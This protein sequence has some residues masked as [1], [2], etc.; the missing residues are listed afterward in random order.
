MALIDKE[1]IRAEIERQIDITSI[2]L[3]E[4][5]AGHENGRME[6]LWELRDFIDSLPDEPKAE[7]LEEEIDKYFHLWRQGAS[8]EGCVNADSQFVSIYDCYRI[9]RHF[10]EWGAER[11]KAKMMEEA[12]GGRYMKAMGDVYVE[13]F[14]LPIPED[15]VKAG[16]K[17]KLIILPEDE[18]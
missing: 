10:A 8:D 13:S 12:V 17:V 15:S 6:L 3:S 9:A 4:Y 7:D 14:F 11:L 2:G 5:D 1:T 18:G 16:Q